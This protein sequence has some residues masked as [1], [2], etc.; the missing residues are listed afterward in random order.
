MTQ[1]SDPF[2]PQNRSLVQVLESILANW[3]TSVPQWISQPQPPYK[4]F[5]LYDPTTH[6]PA[7]PS[8]FEMVYVSSFYHMTVVLMYRPSMMALLSNG[9]EYVR[10]HCEGRCDVI[11]ETCVKRSLESAMAVSWMLEKVL[12]SNS[13]MYFFSSYIAYCI[14]QVNSNP[15]RSSSIR[16]LKTKKKRSCVLIFIDVY[17]LYRGRSWVV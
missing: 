12:E 1:A 9:E 14:F 11:N 8:N 17:G 15:L 3:V 16:P 10:L 7:S 2:S 6:S 4:P 13:E 5:W